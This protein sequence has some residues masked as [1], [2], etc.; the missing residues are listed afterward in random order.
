MDYKDE[1]VRFLER[2]TEGLTMLVLDYKLSN[3]E[4]AHE[5]LLKELD[6]L[7]LDGRKVCAELIEHLDK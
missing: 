5:A 6:K 1:G 7:L 3:S 2:L 4:V